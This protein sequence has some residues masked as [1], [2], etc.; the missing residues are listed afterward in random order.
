M[1]DLVAW[2]L[3]RCVDADMS[4][5]RYVW[6]CWCVGLLVCGDAGVGMLVCEDVGVW[7]CWCVRMLVCEEMLV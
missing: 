4:G 2:S 7:G 5:C 3:V 1:Y 6:G